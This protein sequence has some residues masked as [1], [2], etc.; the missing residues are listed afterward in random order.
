MYNLLQKK[1][2][3][4]VVLI[5]LSTLA[6]N[7]CEAQ[8]PKSAEK[9]RKEFLKKD[10]KTKKEAAKQRKKDLKAHQKL[11]GKAT[12][13]RMQDAS[14]KSTRISANKKEPFL[15]RLFTKKR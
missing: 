10:E 15:K 5:F 14:K 7:H 6:T 8:K 9:Q 4:L 12:R 11:Q 3:Y 2:K 13:K 1:F